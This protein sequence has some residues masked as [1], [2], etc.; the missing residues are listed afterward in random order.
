[1]SFLTVLEV[2]VR[3]PVAAIYRFIMNVYVFATEEV[4][5]MLLVMLESAVT[6]LVKSH[7]ELWA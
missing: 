6:T 5:V 7:S 2:A 3:V 4:S 1:M